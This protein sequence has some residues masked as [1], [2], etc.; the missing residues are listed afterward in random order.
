M[1]EKEIKAL[2]ENVAKEHGAAIEGSVKKGI[3]DATKGFITTDQ[4]A[5][6]LEGFGVTDKSIKDLTTAVEKQGIE[7]GKMINGN[8]ENENKP[9][10]QIIAEKK[11]QLNKIAKGDKQ[12]IVKFEVPIVQKANV[13]RTSVA[14]STQAMRLNDVGQVA[15]RGI[16][17][18]SLLRQRPVAPNSNG[19]V[20]YVDQLAPTRA[21]AAIAEAAAFPE[22][23]F[24]WQ[25]FSLN[26]QKIGDQI[27][28]SQESMNDVD[29][30]S[31]EVQNLLDINVRLK[32]DQDLYNGSG[33]SPIISGLLTYAPTYVAPNLTLSTPN[34]FDLIVKVQESINS[35][36][37]SKFKA[38][39]AL[40]SYADWN[41]MLITKTAQSY[42]VPSWASINENGA[43]VNGVTVIPH[44]LVVANT[45]LVGDFNYAQQFTMGGVEIE[46]GYVGSQFIN[47]L[48]T[49]KARKR[50]ALLI[51]N[52]D[53]NGFAKVTDIAA[54]LVLLA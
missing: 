12:T 15:Y 53:L 51:R 54:A 18:S 46:M 22:S 8:G 47:D 20:R 49:I 37:E 25:E 5:A 13:L 38:N 7:L 33:V 35:N 30:I 17:L 2:L 4:L 23:T 9:L 1:E 34:L 43:N 41:A 39:V 44:P 31:G 27:P 32:E 45:M 24:A 19:V 48:M 29:F 21:A 26:L 10:D 11:E 52:V 16:T 36:R 6:K 28:I 42:L 50:T 14:A 40:V 3:E